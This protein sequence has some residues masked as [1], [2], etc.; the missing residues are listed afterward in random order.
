LKANVK[1]SRIAGTFEELAARGQK[2]LMPYVTVGHPTRDATLEIVPALVEGGATH[3]ELGVPFSDPLAD[4][5]VIQRSSHQAL[6]N[7]VTVDFCIETARALRD[8]GVEVPLIFMGYFN[9]LLR[10]GLERFVA[11][12]ADAGVDGF[13]IPDLPPDESAE[14]AELCRR[15]E[16]DLI[17]MVAPTSQESHIKSLADQASG[18]IYCVSVTGVTG[19]RTE[20]A[21]DLS[22]LIQRVR[23]HVKLPIGVGFGISTPEHV[24]EVGRDADAVFVGSALISRLDEADPAE[25]PAVARDFMRYLSGSA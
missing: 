2:G 16:R 3:I 7:G 8:R 12:C 15:Y 5:P 19:A 10:Y 24:E 18:C 25:A 1:P 9:P 4:G 21:S 13:I 6:Q 20:V 23:K 14:M 17:F 11:D 22:S